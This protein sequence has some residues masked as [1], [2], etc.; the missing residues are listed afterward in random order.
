VFSHILPNHFVFLW[1]RIVS[2]VFC[3]FVSISRDLSLSC[4]WKV[5]WEWDTCSFDIQVSNTSI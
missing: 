5:F 1:N 3:F 4:F 2:G